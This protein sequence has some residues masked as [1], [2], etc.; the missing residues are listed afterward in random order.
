MPRFYFL[1]SNVNAITQMWRRPGDKI[2]KSIV[3]SGYR[4]VYRNVMLAKCIMYV[5]KT[6]FNFLI[7]EMKCTLNNIAFAF[8]LDI[9]FYV[10]G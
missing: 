10:T 4:V 2:L 6:M 1:L 3:T 9:I 7:N 5:I 8:Y